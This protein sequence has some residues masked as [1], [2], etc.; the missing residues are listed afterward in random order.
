M[1]IAYVKYIEFLIL[2]GVDIVGRGG[3]LGSLFE[4]SDVHVI[5]H[6]IARGPRVDT[7]SG[8]RAPFTSSS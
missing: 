8:H 4:L 7:F 5:G 3:Y 1:C 6:V 2:M